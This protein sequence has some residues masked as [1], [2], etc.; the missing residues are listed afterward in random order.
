MAHETAEAN[1]IALD[2][3][4]LH[5][6]DRFLDVGFG[7]GHALASAGRVVTSGF[8]AG[9]DH[10]DV[11]FRRARARNARLLRCRR[12]ELI[13]ADSTT[14]PYADDCFNKALSMHTIYFW[15]DAESQLKEL[16]RVVS[17]DGR[18]LIGYRPSDDRKFVQAF[19]TAIYRIRSV[20]EIEAL[21]VQAGFFRV[22]TISR[23]SRSH[24]LALTVADGRRHDDRGS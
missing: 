5:A 3:L 1:R 22:R 10:S 2:L 19:P 4:D 14:I 21:V 6:D 23:R 16:R 15:K 11:M 20:A 18:I 12:L 7:A 9:I 8:L 13:P 24:C 17:S